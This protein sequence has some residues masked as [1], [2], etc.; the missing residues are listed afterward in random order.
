MT[1][2]FIGTG[3][4]SFPP[5][6]PAFRRPPIF[7]IEGK[8]NTET[9]HAEDEY[10]E[11]LFDNG[12]IGFGVFLWLIISTLVIGFKSLN[13]MMMD[14]SPKDKRA[15]PQV[16]DLLGYIVAFIGMLG[17]NFF[18]VSLRFVSS[19][20]Y[21]GLLPS[22]IIN[23]SRGKGLYESHLAQEKTFKSAPASAAEDSFWKTLSEFLIWPARL[24]AWGGLFYVS[25]LILKQFGDLQGPIDRLTMGGEILQWW[26]SWGTLL[27]CVFGLGFVFFRLI[28]LSENPFI[29][30]LVLSAL[31]ILY[32]FWG[33]FKADIHHN[34]AIYFSKERNWDQALSEY[35]TVHRLDPNFAMSLYF[36]GNVFN[37]RFNMQKGKRTTRAEPMRYFL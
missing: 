2:P 26:L 11:E 7:H 25:F 35:Q 15:P 1:Q 22:M 28:L 36:M 30:A 6:Y 21:L 33:Y 20:V 31:P 29:G 13:Q 18:D 17:H 19:G 27:A 10:L 4:G 24:A 8:H 9:D 34:I 3:V 37:D 23:L 32:T 12:I 14:S 16:Y 5:V